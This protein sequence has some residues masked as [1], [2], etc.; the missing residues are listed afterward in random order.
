MLGSEV[1]SKGQQGPSLEG[2]DL[3]AL[4]G[5]SKRVACN[6]GFG[7]PKHDPQQ[8]PADL[9]PPPWLVL[10]QGTLPAAPWPLPA[11]RTPHSFLPHLW[12]P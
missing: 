10:L 6:G 9:L 1:T 5:Q 2:R 3:H 8:H 11:R 4:R 12:P 7:H